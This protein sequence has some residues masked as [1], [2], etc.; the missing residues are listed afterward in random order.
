MDTYG[1]LP[2]LNDWISGI[3]V[4]QLPEDLL[5]VLAGRDPPEMS[6]RAD[7]GWQRIV[8][9]LPL[10]NLSR[11]ESRAYLTRREVPFE[12]QTPILDF[13]HG[14]PLALSLVADVST[15]RCRPC[16]ACSSATPPS[17]T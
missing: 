1:T 11:E 8:R 9:S 15:R 12:Q 5:L 2:S 4:P 16:R 10:E 13:T 3:F 7:T 6:W 14:H 17:T